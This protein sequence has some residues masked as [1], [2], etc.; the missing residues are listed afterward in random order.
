MNTAWTEPIKEAYASC[1]SDE[2][3]LDTLQVHHDSMGTDLFLVA[4]RVDH[5]F[6]LE[7]GATQVFQACAFALSLPPSGE[8]GAQTLQV[9]IDNTD[10]QVSDYLEQVV[11]TNKPVRLTFRPYLNSDPN[12]PQMNPPLVLDLTDVDVKGVEVS[13]KASFVDVI[14]KQFLTSRYTRDR[15]PSLGNNG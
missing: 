13:G 10:K 4:D 6:K 14:N 2:V 7:G 1:P 11:D 12:T 15:F 8:G 3:I 9:K 5:T